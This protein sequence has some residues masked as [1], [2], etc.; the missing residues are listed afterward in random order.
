MN[1]KREAYAHAPFP[2]DQV[3]S[4]LSSAKLMSREKL[5]ECFKRVCISHERL[6]LEVEG[7]EILLADDVKKIDAMTER[8]AKLDKSLMI[9]GL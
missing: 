8:L 5:E 3:E 7:A 2:Q 6:R 1:I 4:M 9:K